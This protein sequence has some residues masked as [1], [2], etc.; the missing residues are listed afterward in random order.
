MPGIEPS[1]TA[2]FEVI[3]SILDQMETAVAAGQYKQAESARLRP[4]RS[5]MLVQKSS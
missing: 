5:T 3:A 4:T 1:G 2:D